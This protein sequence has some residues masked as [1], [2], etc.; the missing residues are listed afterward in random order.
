MLTGPRN[1]SPRPR[2]T[3]PHSYS[4]HR[5]FLFVP[6]SEAG[7]GSPGLLPRKVSIS[8]TSTE[9]P[10]SD[11]DYREADTW[12]DDG[13]EIDSP[14]PSENNITADASAIMGWLDGLFRDGASYDK[15]L[16]CRGTAA[17][18]LLDLLQ[19]LLDYEWSS[20]SRRRLF[21]ALRRLSRVS[22]FHPRCFALPHLELGE[23]VAGGSFSDVYKASLRG[24]SVAAK[25][26]RV[27][28]KTEVDAA[29]KNFAQEAVIWRQLSHPNLLPFFG[30]YYLGQRVCLVSPWI[31]NGDI[32]TFLKNHPCDID[33]RISFISGVAL[34]V[35]HLHAKDVVHGDLKTANV[36]VTS[37]F[38]ACIA[39]FG[40][41]S[42]VIGLS[43]IQLT[44][45]STRARGGTLRYQ[46]PELLK[47]GHNNSESDIFALACV[48]YELLTE[49]LP[50]Q[51]LR[52]PHAVITAVLVGSRPSPTASCASHPALW[53][54]IQD[55]WQ[56][57][58]EMRPTA[59]QIV[60]RLR[61]PALQ[62]SA[63][64]SGST[65]DWDDTLTSRFRRSLHAERSFPTVAELEY[66]IFGGADVLTINH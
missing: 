51:E 55:C 62:A 54:L 26:V 9:L 32:H 29:V 57:Q 39:D 14:L 45:S 15:F 48:A 64:L 23:H 18:Q 41:S 3:S 59:A 63:A 60:E 66:V 38:R 44:N 49:K 34:G 30:L 21:A 12:S 1:P 28:N 19:D 43:S 27:F 17:Q 42:I 37:S 8:S 40:L 6:T 53:D 11:L 10:S 33:R 5:R 31:K 56:E 46:A 65:T 7:V 25:V 52:S 58:P 22:G 13:R 20:I 2:T 36:F 50:F 35:K 4:L 16:A 61:I 47:G 24:Q